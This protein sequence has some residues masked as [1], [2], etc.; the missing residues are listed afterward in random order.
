M[1]WKLVAEIVIGSTPA[2]IGL[3]AYLFKI[4]RR[5]SVFLVEHEILVQDFA[6]RKLDGDKSRLPTRRDR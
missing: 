5:V 6:D 4:D 2:V 1:D 3:L